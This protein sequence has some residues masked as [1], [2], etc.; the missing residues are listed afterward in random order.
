VPSPTPSSMFQKTLRTSDSCATLQTEM[1]FESPTLADY[2]Q[3]QYDYNKSFGKRGVYTPQ[4]IVDGQVEFVGS[5]S[6]DANKA[7]MAAAVTQ[8]LVIGL[9]RN[10]TGVTIAI[11]PQDT[12]MPSEVWATVVERELSTEVSS[13]I[14]VPSPTPSSMFQKTLRTSD[15]CATL[16]TE[17]AF[18]SPTLPYAYTALNS[19][20]E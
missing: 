10:G 2:T 3:R 13:A 7:I 15:S 20:F 12:A 17:M 11:A 16:Q 9:S 5:S 18:E 19:A 1:A 4:M 8:H 6:R 14:F